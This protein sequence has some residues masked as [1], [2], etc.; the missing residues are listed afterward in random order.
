MTIRYRNTRWDLV[1]GTWHMMWF[2]RALR[3]TYAVLAAFLLYFHFSY[4]GVQNDSLAFRL[5]YAICTSLF[6]LGAAAV[7]GLVFAALSVVLLKGKGMLGEHRVTLTDEGVEESTAFNR[8]LNTWEGVQGIR[9]TRRFY[10]LRVTENT[11][12][13]VPKNRPLLEGDLAGFVEEFRTRLK[14]A[15]HGAPTGRPHARG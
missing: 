6:V 8:S 4:S 1:R 7:V 2:S 14:N 10:F 9:E 12:H 15:S 3:Y 11:G 13:L 5:S